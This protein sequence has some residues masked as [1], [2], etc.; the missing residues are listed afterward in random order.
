[1]I[2]IDIDI[3]QLAN[4]Y[5]TPA[6]DTLCS[7]MYID[8]TDLYIYIYI[9]IYVYICQLADPYVTPAGNTLSIYM[10]IDLIDIY[11]YIYYIYDPVKHSLS[12]CIW[13]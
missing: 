1:L 5:A 4:I 9:Y 2:Y 8:L 13:I 10:Y 11:I 7:Y 6:G 12:I 3:C